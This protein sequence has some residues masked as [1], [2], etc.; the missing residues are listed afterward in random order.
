MRKFEF[1]HIFLERDGDVGNRT[2]VRKIRPTNVYERSRFLDSPVVSEPTKE[3]HQLGAR[4][5]KSFFHTTSTGQRMAPWFYDARS[6]H[7][8]GSG[9]GGRG[10][11]LRAS[12]PYTR[13]CSE[14][15]SSVGSAIG[16]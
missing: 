6:F 11:S 15:K 1:P 14:R 4:T 10:P 3:N 9:E 5:R 13:L 7:R 2:R 16:T 8:P 12:R